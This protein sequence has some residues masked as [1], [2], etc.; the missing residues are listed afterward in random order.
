MCRPVIHIPD[1][2]WRQ[3]LTWFRSSKRLR[4][5]GHPDHRFPCLVGPVETFAR[6]SPLDPHLV[7]LPSVLQDASRTM[8]WRLLLLN[9]DDGVSTARSETQALLPKNTARLLVLSINVGITVI[10]RAKQCRFRDAFDLLQTLT[11]SFHQAALQLRIQIIGLIHSM[12]LCAALRRN[13][14]R[15]VC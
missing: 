2:C 7:V 5:G 10:S 6:F 12:R 9:L 14:A 15:M 11:V 8:R 13:L 1:A 3:E 4:Q